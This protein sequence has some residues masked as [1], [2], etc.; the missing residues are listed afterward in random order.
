MGW[1]GC[2]LLLGSLRSRHSTQDLEVGEGL[3]SP[4]LPARAWASPVHVL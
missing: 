3:E 2:A 1:L 4:H